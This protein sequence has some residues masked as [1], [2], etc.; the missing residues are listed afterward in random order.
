[1][2]VLLLGMLV[3]C[4]LSGSGGRG[5]GLVWHGGLT[6]ACIGLWSW[7][8]GQAGLACLLAVVMAGGVGLLGVQMLHVPASGRE[9]SGL[10]LAGGLACVTVLAQILTH[11]VGDMAQHFMVMAALCAVLCG[12]WGAC[13]ARGP[14]A[15]CAGLACGL[16]GIMLLGAR[17]GSTSVMM[18][19]IV[20]T[21]VLNAALAGMPRMETDPS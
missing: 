18:V 10:R 16:D 17:A 5:G 12:V 2:L 14:V 13:I 19:A 15:L 9:R 20:A 3:I 7:V 6:A 21:A 4:S 8:Q 11:G 1:M